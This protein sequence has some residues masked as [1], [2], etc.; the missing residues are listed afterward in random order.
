M[1][2]FYSIIHE[3]PGLGYSAEVP[4]LPGCY[5]DGATIEEVRANLK[6]AIQLHLEVKDDEIAGMHLPET[7]RVM[8][9]AV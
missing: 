6:E 8:E 7:S 1:C 4:A 3:E 2:K 5:T 9:V